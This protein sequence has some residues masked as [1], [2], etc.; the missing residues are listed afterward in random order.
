MRKGAFR[1]GFRAIAFLAVLMC[2]HAD[3]RAQGG[4]MLLGAITNQINQPIIIPSTRESIFSPIVIVP[5]IVGATETPTEV[6]TG[7]ESDVA[8][9]EGAANQSSLTITSPIPADPIVVTNVPSGFLPPDA[10][11][12]NPVPV[13]PPPI[14]T[15]PIPFGGTPFQP[16]QPPAVVT[17]NVPAVIVTPPPAL[18]GNQPAL[19]SGP[20]GLSTGSGI[21]GPPPAPP[22]PL[23][24]SSSSRR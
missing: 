21:A 19:Q 4:V 13:E 1:I 6:V 16:I 11:P 2:S 8:V 7:A 12:R 22:P 14:V 15:P 24:G 3:L 5:P 9:L 20:P 17:P 10:S 18:P 23:N